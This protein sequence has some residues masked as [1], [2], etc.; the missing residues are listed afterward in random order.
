MKTI[1]MAMPKYCSQHT[2][3]VAEQLLRTLV[4]LTADG[5][6]HSEGAYA[7]LYV[8]CAMFATSGNTTAELV[9]DLIEDISALVDA[10]RAETTR[11]KTAT[12]SAVN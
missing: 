5:N 7:S 3:D 6:D 4:D 8:M 2:K 11:I 1:P 12:S 10:N 9:Q